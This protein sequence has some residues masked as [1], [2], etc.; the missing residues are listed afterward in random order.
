MSFF[1]SPHADYTLSIF[2]EQDLQILNDEGNQNMIR[3]DGQE[4]RGFTDSD[5]KGMTRT[6]APSDGTEDSTATPVEVQVQPVITLE[7]FAYS[8]IKLLQAPATTVDPLSDSIKITAL[9]D[10]YEKAVDDDHLRR[11]L[12][13]NWWVCFVWFG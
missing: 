1:G 10:L 9:V 13:K 3:M 4:P 12:A 7:E 11:L 5:Y 6:A 8:E 2:S